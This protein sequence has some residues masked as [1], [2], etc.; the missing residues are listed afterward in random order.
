MHPLL[1]LHLVYI[2]LGVGAICLSRVFKTRAIVMVIL[3]VSLLIVMMFI[4][5]FRTVSREP[6]NLLWGACMPV[7]LLLALLTPGGQ[8]RSQ[9][10]DP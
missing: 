1:T 4:E 3:S 2:V 5:P 10:S 9:Q 6:D 8:H 7:L